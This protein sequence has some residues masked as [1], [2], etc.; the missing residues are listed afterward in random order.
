MKHILSL[1]LI[2]LTLFSCCST[3]KVTGQN[4]NK[5]PKHP[6]VKVEY[7]HGEAF[8]MFPRFRASF[9]TK[10]DSVMAISYNMDHMSTCLYHITHPNIMQELTKV[11]EDNKMYAYERSY[12][13]PR[14]YDG[15][16][17]NFSAKFTSNPS[18][19]ADT[20]Y[21]NSSGSNDKP[22][23]KGLNELESKM[24][25]ALST[26]TFLYTCNEEGKEIPNVPIEMRRGDSK[27]IDY[28][29]LMRNDYNGRLDVRF[30]DTDT[31]KYYTAHFNNQIPPKK[32]IKINKRAER[33]YGSRII[34]EGN[35]TPVI[36]LIVDNGAVESIAISDLFSEEPHTTRFSKTRD[37]TEVKLVNG[38]VKGID[39]K[40]NEV[41]IKWEKK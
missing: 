39:K 38:T 8:L 17:W 16:S 12:V 35:N 23:G 24:K 27:A 13:D 40:G 41:D 4:D 21:I 26:A 25:E 2:L 30:H 22:K 1:P 14:V 18:S 20:E 7:S 29:W 34:I 31:S 19:Y 32:L 9:M 37:L 3:Q 10:G 33:C 36:Y 11:I 5:M 28:L 15:W 6:L